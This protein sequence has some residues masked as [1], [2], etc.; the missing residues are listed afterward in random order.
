MDYPAGWTCERTVVHFEVYLFATLPHCEAL[1][2]A[3][4]IEAC[5]SC[6]QRLVLFELPSRRA[7]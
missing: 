7:G 6:A 3:E 1:A 4:H 2:V 5:V